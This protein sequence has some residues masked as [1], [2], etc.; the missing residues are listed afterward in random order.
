MSVV[1]A[2]EKVMP[3]DITGPPRCWGTQIQSHGR[4]GWLLNATLTTLLSKNYCCKI[5]RNENDINLGL[6]SKEGYG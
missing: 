6:S 3:G 1:E 4:P 2:K 5:Q